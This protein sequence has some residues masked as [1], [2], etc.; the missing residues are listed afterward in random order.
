FTSSTVEQT[1]MA[2][3]NDIIDLKQTLAVSDYLGVVAVWLVFFVVVFVISFSCLNWC[4]IQK[5]D[6][7]TIFEKWGAPR[8]MKM[9]VH[10]LSVVERKAEEE[11]K[12]VARLL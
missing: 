3:E 2:D 6:D 9:G 11:R 12:M 4:C 8:K 7:I 10:R 5:E 1:R